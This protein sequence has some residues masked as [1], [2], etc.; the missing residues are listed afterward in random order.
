MHE[1]LY[2]IKFRSCCIRCFS[3][4]T[5]ALLVLLDQTVPQETSRG[6]DALLLRRNIVS[7][8]SLP[9]VARLSPYSLQSSQGRSNQQMG[10]IGNILSEGHTMQ[11]YQRWG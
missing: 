8:V 10:R 1:W 6:L 2:E 5:Q 9:E 7:P 3:S 11:R 4:C